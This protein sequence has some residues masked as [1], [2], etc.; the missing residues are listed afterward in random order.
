[1][2]VLKKCYENSVHRCI[3]KFTRTSLND[4]GEN[5]LTIRG[6]SKVKTIS[7]DNNKTVTVDVTKRWS[8]TILIQKERSIYPGHCSNNIYKTTK[9]NMASV[10]SSYIANCLVCCY[11]I[12]CN[13]SSRLSVM[14]SNRQTTVTIGLNA[15]KSYF[16]C[17]I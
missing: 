6:H 12:K 16:I 8:V 7:N 5:V 3:L 13:Y 14:F 2:H 17:S 10:V 15:S 1:M 4:I 9:S 11:L